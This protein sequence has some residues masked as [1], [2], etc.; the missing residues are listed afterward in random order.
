LSNG[1]KDRYHLECVFPLLEF[2]LDHG[3]VCVN[4]FVIG[5]GSSSRLSSLLKAMVLQIK[6]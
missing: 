1:Q 4:N 5:V 3:H 2:P 6:G